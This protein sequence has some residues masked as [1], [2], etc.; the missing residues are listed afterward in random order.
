MRAL[1]YVVN[2]QPYYSPYRWDEGAEGEEGSRYWYGDDQRIE[3]ELRLDAQ[4]RG[5]IRVPTAVDDNGRDFSVRIEAQVTDASSREVSGNTVVHATHGPFLLSR[6]GQ[7]LCLPRRRRACPV[8]VR[9]IDYTGNPQSGVAATLVLERM[10]YPSGRYNE[11]TAT[12]VGTADRD[13]RRGRHGERGAD[14]AVTAGIVSHP[15]DRRL[16]RSGDHRR[17]MALGAGRR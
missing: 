13:H 6:A 11:P 9:A 16:E 10:T 1:R 14:V 3:G 12:E 15:R 8:S 17:H 7:R 4:G 2:Q 5:E